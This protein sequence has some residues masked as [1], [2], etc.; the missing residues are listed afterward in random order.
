MKLLQMINPAVKNQP[1]IG[2]LTALDWPASAAFNR[3]L[4]HVNPLVLVME[5]SNFA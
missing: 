4:N 2:R 1:L 3:L 5:Y